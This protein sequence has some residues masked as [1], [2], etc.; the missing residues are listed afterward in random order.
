V[1]KAAALGIALFLVGCN[2]AQKSCDEQFQCVEFRGYAPTDKLVCP[3]VMP[4]DGD[5]SRTS[6][7]GKCVATDGKHEITHYYYSGNPTPVADLQSMCTPP[8][9]TWKSR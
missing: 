2:H 7:I 1:T 3:G 9:G 6:V 5:C 4:H 8:A